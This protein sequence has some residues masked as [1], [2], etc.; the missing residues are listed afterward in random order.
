MIKYLENDNI[1]KAV[2]CFKAKENQFLITEYYPNNLYDYVKKS[3]SEKTIKNI[4]FQLVTA[5][6]SLHD[7]SYIHRDIKPDNILIDENGVLKL[8]DFDLTRKIGDN[9]KPLSK[10]VVTLYYR[11]PEIFFGDTHYSFPVDMW[12]IGCVLCELFLGEPIFKGRCELE[13]LGKIMS[14]LGTPTE[15]N[16]P[17]VTKLPNYLP[18]QK[19]DGELR[20]QLEEKMPKDALDLA[21]EMLTLNPEKRPTCSEVLSRAFFYDMNTNE[22]IKVEMDLK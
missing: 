2:E 14:S 11:A 5:V 16:W 6:K 4:I 1:I 17:G 3:L 13:T 9:D 18:F 21:E 10:N 20:K 12:S 8:T 15:E 19:A 22:E 7:K